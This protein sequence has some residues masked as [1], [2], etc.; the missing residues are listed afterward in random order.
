MKI[1]TILL[2]IQALCL[3][4]QIVSVI[5]SLK[6]KIGDA[7]ADEKEQKIAKIAEKCVYGFFIANMVIMFIVVA[8]SLLVIP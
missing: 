7:S 6:H 4:F 2:I 3:V 1:V 5:V 8:I